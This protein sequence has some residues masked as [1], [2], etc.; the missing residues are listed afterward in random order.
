MFD[1]ITIL[2]EQESTQTNTEKQL[3][4]KIDGVVNQVTTLSVKCGQWWC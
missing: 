4:E 1:Q 3:Q 2:I